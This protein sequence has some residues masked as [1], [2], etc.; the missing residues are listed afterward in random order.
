MKCF[1]VIMMVFI[2]N[3]SIFAR[4]LDQAFLYSSSGILTQK[5]KI[6]YIAENIANATTL[7]DEST[8]LPWQKRYVVLS[9]DENGVKVVRVGRSTLP[10]GKYYDPAVPQ[11]NAEGFV[12]FPN[13]NLPDE[14][15]NMSFS[16]T[17]FEANVNAYKTTKAVYQSV[18]E[19]IK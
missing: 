11:S 4:S 9:P 5:L 10:F 12:S 2:F 14:M 6:S 17:V 13:V 1:F 8:G 16:E 3:S 18:A 19:M 7:E 15:V